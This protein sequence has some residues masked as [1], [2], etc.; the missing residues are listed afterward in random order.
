PVA[1]GA[2]RERRRQRQSAPVRAAA[3]VAAA[4]A[5]GLMGLMV[6][7]VVDTSDKVDRFAR[8]DVEAAAAS[9]ARDTAARRATLTSTDGQYSAEAVLLPDGTG[10]LTNANLPTLPSGRTYQLWAVV[11]SAKI[12]VG[13]LGERP[14]VVAF[15]AAG[16]VSA[17]AITDEVAGGVVA[18]VRQPT[19]VGTVA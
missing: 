1:L 2:A 3:A 10:Y 19:V 16:N 18:S 11:G 7:K 9:A 8:G 6:V 13:V 17:L 5:V 14:R 4:A 15:Q 12:S